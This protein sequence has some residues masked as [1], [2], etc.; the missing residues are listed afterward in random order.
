MIFLK[1]ASGLFGTVPNHDDG[2][3]KREKERK[4][5]HCHAEADVL[6][7]VG[8]PRD[9]LSIPLI[10]QAH[11][12][13]IPRLVS[14]NGVERRPATFTADYPA[15]ANAA[16]FLGPVLASLLNTALLRVRRALDRIKPSIGPRHTGCGVTPN[17]GGAW[18]LEAY[19]QAIF[20]QL[21]IHSH[22]A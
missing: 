1:I 15:P 5:R 13:Q 22:T 16:A 18:M 7:I 4:P 17:D 14:S 11:W 8:V 21:K 6:S 2:E 9:S 19:L 12:M 20:R 3:G 10:Q